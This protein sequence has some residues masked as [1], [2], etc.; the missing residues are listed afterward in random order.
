VHDR[1]GDQELVIEFVR[2][3]KKLLLASFAKLDVIG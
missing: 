3:G 1:P 2:H